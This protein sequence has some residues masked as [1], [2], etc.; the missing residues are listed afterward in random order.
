LDKILKIFFDLF[1]VVFLTIVTQIGGLIYLICLVFHTKLN[2]KTKYT[3][4]LC[5]LIL[6][7]FATFIIAPLLAPKFGREKV[8]NEFIKPTNIMTIV[9]NRNYVKKELN[10]ILIQTAKELKNDGIIVRYLDANF[11]FIDKFPLLPHLSHND[12]KKIDLSLIYQNHRGKILDKR[13][14]ISGYGAFVEPQKEETNQIE[15]CKNNGYFQYDYP[16]YLTFGKINRDIVFSE[17]GTKKLISELLKSN[18]IDKIFIEPHLKNRLAL[19][20][21]KIRYHG[22]RAV[23]HDDHIHI[24]IK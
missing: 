1:L 6:Y 22:C 21:N 24:Q 13:K 5:F 2:N 20:N 19:N 8:N 18:K 7:S 3:K 17:I 15:K 16:K 11:P 23:R 4:T 10:D 9:L 14:S 12:G